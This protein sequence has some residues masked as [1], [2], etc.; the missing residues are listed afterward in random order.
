MHTSIYAYI[1][2][3]NGSRA[4]KTDFRLVFYRKTEVFTFLVARVVAH[5][6]AVART[7]FICNGM[8]IKQIQCVKVATCSAPEIDMFVN[9]CPRNSRSLEVLKHVFCK[10]FMTDHRLDDID[11]S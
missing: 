3:Y 1:Y 5:R 8:N 9:C 2:A 4:I 11:I 10:Y 7:T 6:T